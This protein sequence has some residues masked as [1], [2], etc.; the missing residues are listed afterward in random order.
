MNGHHIKIEEAIHQKYMTKFVSNTIPFKIYTAKLGRIYYLFRLYI[1]N[2]FIIYLFSGSSLMHKGFHLASASW[3]Y[4]LW[5]TVFSCCRAQALGSQASVVA[6]RELYSLDSVVASPVLSCS[7]A[8]GIIP[9]QR[10]NQ[11]SLHW[12]VNSYLL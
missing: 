11:C 7:E 3:G 1:Y 5:W 2:K 6:A 10:L 9:D 4:S 12:Q 8:C